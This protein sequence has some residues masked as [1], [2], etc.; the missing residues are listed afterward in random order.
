MIKPWI[1]VDLDGT[2]ATWEG[3]ATRIGKPVPL[4]LTRVVE[5]LEEGIEVRIFTARASAPEMIPP[6]KEWLKEWGLPDL[7]ITCCKDFGMIALYDDRVR[8]VEFN[9]GRLISKDIVYD[10]YKLTGKE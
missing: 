8:Q 2:L 4:M 6:I 3:T 7:K 10:G 5:W 1:G 9:T